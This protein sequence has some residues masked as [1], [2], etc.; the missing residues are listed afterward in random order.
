M[1][2]CEICGE[3][4]GRTIWQKDIYLWL[5]ESCYKLDLPVST[6]GSNDTIEGKL[7]RIMIGQIRLERRLDRLLND[8]KQP[9]PPTAD[10]L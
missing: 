3:E 8:K 4:I 7:T 9:K 2:D 1:V 10:P 6:H 5:C